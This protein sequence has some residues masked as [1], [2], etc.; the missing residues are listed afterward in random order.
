MH[1]RVVGTG[2]AVD[3]V[4]A[5]LEDT[6]VTVVVDAPDVA[7]GDRPD[8]EPDAATDVDLGVVV[9][10]AGDGR[11]DDPPADVWIAVERGGI[12]GH[13]VSDLD[14]SVATFDHRT[15]GPPATYTD[16]QARVASTVDTVQASPNGAPAAARLAGAVAGRRAVAVLEG[17][18]LGGTV[19]ELSGVTVGPTRTFLPVP[20]GTV[21]R[22][23]R[24][25]ARDVAL[26]DTSSR[27]ERA[28]DD[29]VGLVTQVGE[30]ESFPL[31]YYIAQTADTTAYSDARA[32]ALA[33][34]VDANWDRAFVKGLGEA[35]ERYSAGVYRTTSFIRAPAR[36]R[37]NPVTPDAF[38]RPD[39]ATTPGIDDPIAWVT[40]QDL[41]SGTAVSLPAAFVQY[42]PHS[43]RLGP[44]ITTG[45]GLGN[46]GVE[47]LLSGLYEVVER[48]ATMLAWYST[49]E[50]LAVTVRDEATRAASPDVAAQYA[51]LVRR[52]RSEGLSAT[53]LLVTQD[54]DVPV[55]AAAVHRDASD[56]ESD[57]PRFA[58][59]S[60]ADLDAAAAA[61]DA[62]AEA[63]QNWMELRAMG[64]EQAAAEDGAIGEYADFP[65][66]VQSFV[67]APTSVPA[68]EVGPDSVPDGA[69]ELDAV[70][71]RV[72]A[73]GL[74]AYASRLTPRD[75]EAL[76][77]EVVRVLV[78]AA[79]PL[80]VGEPYFGDRAE[81]VPGELGFDP[82]L[83]RPYH[84]FP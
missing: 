72:R 23:P 36:T 6:D 81:T 1:V 43:E 39:S 54:V 71:D 18:S 57:W 73:A 48:D 31:P 68:A 59:G 67:D 79:Q 70:L 74:S 46:A 9:G 50:P 75:V 40:G 3:A 20:D 35:L 49:Y 29:R 2:P 84:P 26:E 83:D 19:V 41:L 28:L 15:E 69:A 11:F 82:R 45:L 51:T 14:A 24:R 62:L 17:A 55:V 44:A 38:V 56:D 25:E 52:A 42:P 78:P 61:R 60:A 22:E 37:A 63:I 77:F 80:F 64:P 10:P 13:P 76:G 27:M 21:D 34:G 47:A 58:A 16:L 65:P 66:A 53:A 30:R 5:A 33:A 4:L 7:D 8:T 32:A 12:G